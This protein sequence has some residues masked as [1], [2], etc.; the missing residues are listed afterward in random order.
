MTKEAINQVKERMNHC[1]IAK[2]PHVKGHWSDITFKVLQKDWDTETTRLFIQEGDKAIIFIHP[3]VSKL[4]PDFQ[5]FYIL[6]EFGEYLLMKAGP[7]LETHWRQKLTFPTTDQIDAFQTRLNQG[8]KNYA[9]VVKSMKTPVD[10]LVASHLANAMLINGQAFAGA[11]NV[12]VREWG[13]TQEFANLRRF[14]SLIP[15]TTAYCPREV[16]KDFGCAFASCVV[17]DLK[18]VL[19]TSVKEALQQI[20]ERVINSAR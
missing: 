9:E 19:H 14:Y 2:A 3:C 12:K 11:C 4:S 13:P 17:F 8:F 6:R 16:S 5:A 20:I 7:D 10:R 15:L 1:Q 18:T